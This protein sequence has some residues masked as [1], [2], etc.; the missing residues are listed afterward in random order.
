MY[1]CRIV[2]RVT[3]E[4]GWSPSSCGFTVAT[5]GAEKQQQLQRK[6]TA[7]RSLVHECE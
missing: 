3:R 1:V 6:G 4:C 2:D 7:D 5:G